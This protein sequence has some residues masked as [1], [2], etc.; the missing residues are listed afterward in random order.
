MPNLS[1][2]GKDEIRNLLQDRFSKDLHKKLSEIPKPCALKDIYKGANRIKDAINRNEKIVIVG[3]YDVD[4]VISC[5]I[6]AEF[7]D[8]LGVRNYRVRIP[9]RFK[10]GYG[11][12]PEI[13]DELG[14]VSL[15]ITVDNGIS[16]NEAA[17]ECIKKGI[18]LIITDHHMPPPILPNA[19]AIINP[20]QDAC[21]FP[22]IEICGA[23]VAWYLVGAIKEV[24]EI[25]YDMSKFLDLLSIAII[26]DM[27]ELRDM[28]RI[29]VRLGISKLNS[30]DRKA[31]MAIRDFYGKER[32]EC[33]DISFLI[34][35]LINSAGRMNDAIN[36]YNFLRSKDINE[37]F[38]YLDMIVEFNNDRKEEER[39][40]FESSLK[41]VSEDDHI[42]VKWGEEWHEGVIGIVASRLAK[43]FKKP[44]IVFSVDKD[45]A[46]GSARSV[47]KIDIL[48]LIAKQEHL[49]SSYGGH[50]GAA[51]LVCE[52][53][54]LEEFKL[55]INKS[56]FLMD[57]H[58]HSISD[59][60]LGEIKANEIDYD[61]L[62]ILEFY[63]PY[64]QK[65][66]RPIFCLK[67][68]FV[69][70][71]KLIGKDQNHLKLILQK[72]D[73][74]LEA[75]F[76]NHTRHVK[77]GESIDIVFSISKN[78]FRGLVT[79]QLMIKEIL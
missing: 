22:N 72:D 4:G 18:D 16:A 1:K 45:R 50:K 20:K 56:C 40:L 26:A 29:L 73:K 21:C 74:I 6:L 44:A 49:L 47:G 36:S 67:N 48:S 51:G 37:A 3:D 68:V 78:S 9:N 14:D 12:N 55:E 53:C 2:L 33:D 27:M 66:P 39:H 70:N 34:A 64:G 23:Q 24:C 59:E 31:F 19:Y 65:N 13:I 10:D 62:E 8:F 30:T 42:I 17:D 43:H 79:P 54:N 75:L 77:I 11:L 76:F 52:P 25:E 69:K 35:P 57:L 58:T 60:L 61:L 63:E 41:D 28:N 5:V 15:I 46:K 32:F 7:F 38:D 71:E